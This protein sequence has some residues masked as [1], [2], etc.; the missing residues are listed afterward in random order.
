MCR[1][2][3]CAE[4]NNLSLPSG[5]ILNGKQTDVKE[6]LGKHETYLNELNRAA[7]LR[8]QLGSHCSSLPHPYNIFPA[9]KKF[10]SEMD[11]NLR[12][13]SLDYQSPGFESL[14]VGFDGMPQQWPAS[15]SHP[16]MALFDKHSF[17]Q[18]RYFIMKA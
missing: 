2:I 3:D 10:K 13:T 14:G 11:I 9:N 1:D 4:D 5:Y 18:V 12:G 16:V 6:N 15:S 8:L 17:P 7:G